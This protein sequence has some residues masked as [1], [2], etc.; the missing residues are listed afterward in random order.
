VIA[1]TGKGRPA[2]ALGVV[3]A[4]EVERRRDRAP[5]RRERSRRVRAP[6]GGVHGLLDA[7]RQGRQAAPAERESLVALAVRG[8]SITK[9][10]VEL[11]K[12]EPDRAPA[13]RDQG[14]RDGK[15]EKETNAS[16]V[17]EDDKKMAPRS[18]PTSRS[19]RSTRP[20]AAAR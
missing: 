16:A 1:L 12:R 3:S 5:A 2:E 6:E 9:E 18:A 15:T 8:G 10:A 11:V 13:D 14:G 17:T 4:L 20:H 7:R 19:W